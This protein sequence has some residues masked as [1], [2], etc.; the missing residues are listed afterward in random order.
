MRIELIW[1]PRE[2]N[3]N[4]REHWGVKA[5]S[6]KQYR[7]YCR[8]IAMKHPAPRR[9]DFT[10][11]FLPPDMRLRDKDNMIRM[12]KAGQDGLADAWRTDD[13]VFDVS[14]TVGDPVEGGRVI[15]EA[16]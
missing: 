1:P 5:R 12:F 3:P 6:T 2:L 14:Y 9:F 10:V 15:V 13:H 7:T 16:A 8:M 4:V 11:T